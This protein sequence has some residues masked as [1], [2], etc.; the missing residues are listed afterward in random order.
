[1]PTQFQDVTQ[2]S[3][4]DGTKEPEFFRRFVD[5]ANRSPGII[6]SKTAILA[7]LR[8][9][10]GE[11]VLDLGCGLG[12]DAFEMARLVGSQGRV[13]GLDASE[14]MISEARQ[15]AQARDLTVQFEIGDAQA[16]RFED[17]TFDA[18]RAE[19]ML[20]HVPDADRAIHEMVRVTRPGGRL[21]VFD[22]DFETLMID[23]P[24]V[25]ITRRITR[26]FC[27]G[28]KNGWIGR[29]L[30]RLLKQRGIADI[31]AAPHTVVMSCPELELLLSGHLDHAQNAGIIT[32]ADAEKW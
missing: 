8:L 23:S 4:I 32:A 14:T 6:A 31:S 18:C 21:S 11:K 19:R 16:L 3:T 5:A 13:V 22:L 9:K 17:D 2:F 30:S 25:E 10:G 12:D 7:G 28:L 29:Q 1:M 15:R 27:D 20:M 24:Y 26:S